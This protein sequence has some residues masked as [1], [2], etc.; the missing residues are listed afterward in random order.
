[1]A[2]WGILLPFLVVGI[3]FLIAGFMADPSALTDDGYP[4]KSFFYI[5]GG[6]F[7]LL[8]LLLATGLSL[9][10]ATKRK[11]IEDLL[12]TGQQGEAVILGLE[13]TGV[14][15]NHDPRVRI[16]LEVHIAGYSPYQVKKTMV[17]PLI[18]LSQVQV[19]STVQVL[20]DPS[21]PDKPDKVAL[22]LK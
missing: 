5:M 11:K 16:L 4:L 6:G 2:K 9:A 10:G 14:L 3:G 13:D 8:P 19:G 18:R 15:I 12:A 20:A 17:L 7:L 1:M 21:K 22:L